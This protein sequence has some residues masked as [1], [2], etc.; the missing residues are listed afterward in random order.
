[1]ERTASNAMQGAFK[2]LQGA[3][4]QLVCAARLALGTALSLSKTSSCRTCLRCNEED[5][6]VDDLLLVRL[7]Q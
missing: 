5:N 2:P 7:I 6:V 3:S 4:S 1:M